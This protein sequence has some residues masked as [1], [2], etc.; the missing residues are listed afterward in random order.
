MPISTAILEGL[1]YVNSEADILDTT[2][3]WGYSTVIPKTTI[4]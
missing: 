4:F 3:V 2:T 1:F